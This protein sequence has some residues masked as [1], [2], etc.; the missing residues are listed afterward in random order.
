M[1]SSEFFVSFRIGMTI[2]EILEGKLW[3]GSAPIQVG[4]KCFGEGETLD[5]LRHSGITH[6]VNCTP[7]FPFPTVEQLP[8]FQEGLRVGVQDVDDAPVEEYFQQ[9]SNFLESAFGKGG[10]V[11]VH[12]ETGKSRSAIMVLAYRVLAGSQPL[13]LAWEDTKAKRGYVLPK[14]EFV[15]KLHC[16]SEATM[17]DQS[18][19]LEEYGLIYLL[20][21]YKAYEWTGVG[22]QVV[23][24]EMEK[25][26]G[27]YHTAFAALAAK[28]TEAMSAMS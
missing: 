11:Y 4:G 18:L 12:C 15:R 9:V 8:S 27:D 5:V 7:H 22:E 21:H 1:K 6:V 10:K 28:V 3:L 23:R 25:A 19:P 14:V 20:E 26:G 17:Q 13:R 16:H 2:S 24:Q